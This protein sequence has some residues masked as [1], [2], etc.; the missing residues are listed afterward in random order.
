MNSSNL[1]SKAADVFARL[2]DRYP[3]ADI[4][5]RFDNPLELAVATVLSAQCT[6][7]KVNEVT[8]T[9]FRKYR[10]PQDYLEV[11]EEELQNDIRPTGFYKQKTRAIRGI[12]QALRERH[13]GELPR[14]IE[15]LTAL[16][17]ISVDTHVRRVAGR[18]GLTR[19]T[20][21]EKIEKDLM[22]LYPPCRWTQLSHLLIFHGRYTCQAR[23]PRCPECP[24]ADLCDYCRQQAKRR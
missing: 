20:D 17:G 4:A 12:M 2:A 15:A 22:P 9:L 5:L 24:V 11:P 10:S 8:E 7:K 13:Q 14:T 6:D 16:P 18:I 1:K 21:P 19:N 23:Q 3:D